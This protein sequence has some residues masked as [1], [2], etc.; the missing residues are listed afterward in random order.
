[1]TNLERKYARK[2]YTDN[3]ELAYI[4]N[5]FSQVKDKN[6]YQMSFKNVFNVTDVMQHNSKNILF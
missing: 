1:M 4:F 2:I 3:F 5:I 6:F